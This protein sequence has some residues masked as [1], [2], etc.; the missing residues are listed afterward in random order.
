MAL[1]A[2][3]QL[4]PHPWDTCKIKGRV[5]IG[6]LGIGFILKKDLV[7]N[8]KRQAY[9]SRIHTQSLKNATSAWKPNRKRHI[10][11][12]EKKILKHRAAGF[13]TQ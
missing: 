7:I 2:R 6:H 12:I 9:T 13:I 8:L 3:V 10:E 5:I 11:L 1:T 4:Q